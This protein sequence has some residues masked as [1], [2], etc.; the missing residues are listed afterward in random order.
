MSEMQTPGPAEEAI[1][2]DIADRGRAG[3]GGWWLVVGGRIVQL[4][5]AADRKTAN[6]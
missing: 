6:F 3:A 4:P 1:A 2:K 5:L